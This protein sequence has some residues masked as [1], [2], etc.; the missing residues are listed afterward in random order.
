MNNMTKWTT[1]QIGELK[2]KRIIVT[3]GASGIGYAASEVLASKGAELILA[4]RSI[5]KGEKAAGRIRALHSGAEVAVM[6]LDLGDLASVRQF[7]SEFTG[8]FDR[9]DILI[10]N[11]G[12][13]VPPYS[14]TKDGFELQF[15]TN[16]LGH[17][18]L[19][20]HLLPLLMATPHS[21]VVTVSSIAARRAKINFS[22]L[23][24]TQ[25]YNPMIFY[26]KSKLA[27]LLFATELQHRLEG[28]GSTTISVL[29]HPGITVTNLLSRGSGKETGKIMKTLMSIVAQPA[30]KGALP[31]LYAATH[32]DLRGSEYIG[33]D[34]RGNLWGDPVVT[35]DVSRLFKPE[36]SARLWEVSEELTGL[37]FPI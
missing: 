24:G 31:T 29:C 3:G 4:V 32:P 36:L 5:A 2:G 10:N 14:R 18:A 22:N 16:H 33:P 34:G 19:T 28:A 11:A 1:E 37:K 13:M 30:E 20:A 26:R 12:V 7:A 15:G 27:N 9:L 21:R 6:H 35:N 25:G 23:D 17:F 8:R